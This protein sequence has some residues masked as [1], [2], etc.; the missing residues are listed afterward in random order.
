MKV[1]VSHA[2]A[3]KQIALPFVDLLE[4]GMGISDAFCSSS[5]GAIPN[6]QFFVQHILS[7]LHEG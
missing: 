4:N 7:K 6:G 1:F 2:D 3:D 5:R